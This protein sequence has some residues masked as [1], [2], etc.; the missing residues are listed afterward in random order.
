MTHTPLT[1]A[2]IALLIGICTSISVFI[3][4]RHV[5]HNDVKN[6]FYIQSERITND[7]KFEIEEDYGVI[8]IFKRAVSLL[9]DSA[10][11]MHKVRFYENT[12]SNIE[13]IE[14][15]NENTFL[16][17]K[18]DENYDNINGNLI[19]LSI[20]SDSIKLNIIS[21]INKQPGYISFTFA[22]NQLSGGQTVHDINNRIKTVSVNIIN[23]QAATNSST[24]NNYKKNKS[25]L[26]TT[27]Y[28]EA[29]IAH[30]GIEL[31]MQID[32]QVYKR[33]TTFLIIG[34]ILTLSLYFYLLYYFKLNDKL[35]ATNI[36]LNKEI[37]NK[38]TSETQLR[39]SELL[40]R[41]FFETTPIML[42]K[43]NYKGEL[44]NVNKKW[45]D[46]LGYT[47]AEVIG[48]K[49]SDFLS[50]ESQKLFTTNY[51]QFLNTGQ[52][53]NIAY[54]FVKK[55]GDI[56]E[57]LLSA[58]LNKNENNEIINIQ[59]AIIDITKRKKAET[60]L[61]I[62]EEKHRLL[63]NNVLFPVMV[64]SVTGQ[65]FYANN[66]ATKLFDIG[67]SKFS[68]INTILFWK[69]KEQRKQMLSLLHK[70]GK[71]DNMEVDFITAKNKTITLL[72]SAA[73]NIYE[74]K[75]AIYT[76]A[77]DITEKIKVDKALKTTEQR[78]REL[79]NSNKDAILVATNDRIILDCNNAFEQLFGYK[80]EEIKGK[81]TSHIYANQNHFNEFHEHFL[82]TEKEGQRKHIHYKRKD[83]TTFIGETNPFAYSTTQG[84]LTNFVGI[85]RDVSDKIKLEKEVNKLK[86]AVEQSASAI[87]ITDIN[88]KIEYINEHF[89]ATTGYTKAEAIG[90]TPRLLNSGKHPKE[91]YSVLW[92]TLLSGKIWSDTI[93]NKRKNGEIYWESNTLSPVFDNSNK[94]INF[95][96]IKEDITEQIKSE[97]QILS[98]VLETETAER[99]KFAENL[100]DELGP[101]LSGI[102]LYIQEITHDSITSDQ[103]KMLISQ[104]QE[105]V[106]DSINITK[107]LSH[108]LM[109]SILTDYGL[110]KALK[111]FCEKISQLNNI[112]INFNSNIE[113]VIDNNIDLTIYRITIELINNTLK[114]AQASDI[115]IDIIRSNNTL[116]FSYYDNGKGFNINEQL[117]KQEGL[118]L[119]NII[120][121]INTIK[122][123]YEF[124]SNK[125]KGMCMRFKVD[126]EKLF[127]TP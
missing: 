58:K 81:T 88:G 11:I 110:T 61:K 18:A 38:T 37:Y 108:N 36:R 125:A 35:K 21:T 47:R 75:Q 23:N 98:A 107:S 50:N 4:E 77:N 97:K 26:R 10:N 94:L 67:N 126:F 45:L 71:V 79:F 55:N 64:T 5:I 119:S 80:L 53:D 29:N 12:F 31:A 121:R 123:E 124:S 113:S 70:N 96:A 59:A 40:Y 3:L 30:I 8:Q 117:K 76:I 20:Q 39:E 57:T 68:T 9:P 66:I 44:L 56:I 48:R 115:N 74:G 106:D 41:S 103:K 69:N 63:T 91:F 33:A 92:K 112:N 118:G 104:L 90:Q 73:I 102:K 46:T 1:K 83:G 87:I 32:K 122:G 109:P 65:L 54:Q 43:V 82:N 52:I 22:I 72:L 15:I 86:A 62:S 51:K 49:S 14:P 42:H 27:E 13:K 111:S 120:N 17:I 89:T 114:H 127:I 16:K 99:K 105:M 60:A 116:D 95:I 101:F 2:S 78:Y 84:E 93:L 100:H 7:L 34:L 19:K 28:F 85:I 25:T 24:K 6:D